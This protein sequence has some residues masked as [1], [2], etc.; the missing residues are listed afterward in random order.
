[1]LGTEGRG[2]GFC[3]KLPQEQLN[4]PDDGG[5]EAALVKK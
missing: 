3:P 1:L 5:K 4:L 2:A